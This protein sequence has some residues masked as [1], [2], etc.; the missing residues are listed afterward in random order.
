MAATTNRIAER[1]GVS[2][3]T[4]YQYFPNKRAL[5]YALAEQH[6]DVVRERLDV[7]FARLREQP[8]DWP[9]AVRTVVTTLVEL[10]RDRP[11]LHALMYEY[12]PRNPDGMSRLHALQDD[13]IVEV[14]HQLQRCGRG[15]ADP[16]RTA[17]MLVHSVDAQLHRVVLRKGA[18]AEDL[19]R[20]ILAIG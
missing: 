19:I 2:I 1:A 15:G 6:V 3:G 18:D 9:R 5:L 20:A 16:A 8:P 17:A 13:V 10:H 7:E 12:A 11:R 4:L 14:A